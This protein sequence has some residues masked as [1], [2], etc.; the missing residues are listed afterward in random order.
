MHL[1]IGGFMAF[2]FRFIVILGINIIYPIFIVPLFN[3]LTPLEDEHL[4]ES[5]EALLSRARA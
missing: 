2:C 1:K 4:K 3:K 5:I